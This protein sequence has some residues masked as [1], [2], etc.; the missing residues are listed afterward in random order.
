MHYN[1][2]GGHTNIGYDAFDEGPEIITEFTKSPENRELDS[3]VLENVTENEP[4]PNNKM[5]GAFI[6]YDVKDYRK[7][8]NSP[9]KTVVKREP[10]G[11][12]VYF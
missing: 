8:R 4:E 10:N 1:T 5:K 9:D 12:D 2:P 11:P 3:I 7:G 6:R